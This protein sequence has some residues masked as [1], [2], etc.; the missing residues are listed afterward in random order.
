MGQHIRPGQVVRQQSGWRA[1]GPAHQH[2]ALGTI[3][4]ITWGK[5]REVNA[6][7]QEHPDYIPKD[8]ASHEKHCAGR[9][10]WC[11][12]EVE[13]QEWACQPGGRGVAGH[14]LC[15]VWRHVERRMRQ[16]TQKR[17]VSVKVSMCLC[18][19]PTESLPPLPAIR[20]VACFSRFVN[21]VL[22]N[23]RR[24]YVNILGY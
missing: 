4:Y 1:A 2:R 20:V 11:S 12:A 6:W 24:D 18:V 22:C 8:W 14:S 23:I 17:C 13:R 21:G 3:V 9:S 7:L 5:C 10:A 16:W 19:C 15:P